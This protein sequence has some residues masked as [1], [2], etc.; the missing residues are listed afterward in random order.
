MELEMREQDLAIENEAE[1]QRTSTIE[2][3]L[4]IDGKLYMYVGLAS[5]ENDR[6]FNDVGVQVSD[7]LL[8]NYC[9]DASIKVKSGDLKFNFVDCIKSD[10]NFSTVTGILVFMLTEETELSE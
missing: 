9:K 3:Y 2:R 4:N 1:S 8:G 6:K 5:D 10:E 7:D